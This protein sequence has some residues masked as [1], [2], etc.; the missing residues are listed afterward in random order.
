MAHS[1]RK[2]G[3][4]RRFAIEIKPQTRIGIVTAKGICYGFVNSV[5]GGN[6]IYP[7][8]HEGPVSGQIFPGWM[9]AS[10]VFTA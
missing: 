2:T 10:Q 6:W 3:D 1:T 7:R 9:R 8:F 5:D 4:K